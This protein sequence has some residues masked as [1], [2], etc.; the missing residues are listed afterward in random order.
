[1]QLEWSALRLA[2]ACAPQTAHSRCHDL[3]CGAYSRCSPQG[4][5]W[6]QPSTA[7]SHSGTHSPMH[8]SMRRHSCCL[9]CRIRSAVAYCRNVVT[10]AWARPR[11]SSRLAAAARLADSLEHAL[12]VAVVRRRRLL[13]VRT[14]VRT[15]RKEGRHAQAL[16][17]SHSAVHSVPRYGSAWATVGAVRRRRCQ[18]QRRSAQ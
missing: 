5:P 4:R 12:A 17:C 16:A 11:H 1:M 2:S 18:P 7:D 6:L 10:R 13:A 8:P 14:V 15:G 3:C 9:A